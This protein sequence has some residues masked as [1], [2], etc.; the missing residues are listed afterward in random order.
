VRQQHQEAAEEESAA[1]VPKRESQDHIIRIPDDKIP[2][3]LQFR[4][5]C[6]VLCLDWDGDAL[7]K[8]TYGL[9]QYAGVDLG[10]GSM[11]FMYHIEPHSTG[12]SF[13][14]KEATL[15]FA[16][17]TPVWAKVSSEYVE[18]IVFSSSQARSDQQP[19]YSVSDTASHRLHTDV[20]SRLVRYRET[21]SSKPVDTEENSSVAANN[22]SLKEPEQMENPI[23]RNIV[24]RQISL[25]GQRVADLRPGNNED[26]SLQSEVRRTAEVDSDRAKE[27][28]KSSEGR[29][30]P[31]P[32]RRKSESSSQQQ[33]LAR[34]EVQTKVIRV[35]RCA[36]YNGLKEGK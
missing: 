26:I 34:T 23:P 9:V 29:W 25:I 22:N 18:A 24:A 33:K 14:A 19:V 3:T 36:N 13:Y 15:Q 6:K 32:K 27:P 2:D 21:G 11:D 31:P 8:V 4:P 12:G 30:E 35:P 17:E 28:R 20:P 10:S 1:A 5:G 16:Q 7:P